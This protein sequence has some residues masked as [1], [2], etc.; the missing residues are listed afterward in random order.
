MLL[1]IPDIRQA[2]DYDCGAAAVDAVCRFHGLRARGPAKYANA[3][4][5][6]APSTVEAVLR[7]LGLT[8]WGGPILTG[9][10]GL[11]HLTRAGVPV[12]CPTG[13][14]GGHWVV[15]RGVGRGRV[16][17]HCPVDGP[18]SLPRLSWES[19]WCDTSHTGEAFA[20]WGIATSRG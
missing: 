20:R 5:G 8:V 2:T 9:V 12:L 19:N 1:T 7:S 17:F 14:R 6:M 11:A 16:H 10:G 15:V 3:V 13:L 18:S 4:Q